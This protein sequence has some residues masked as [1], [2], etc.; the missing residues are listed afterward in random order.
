MFFLTLYNK[1]L[2]FL[3]MKHSPGLLLKHLLVGY[4]MLISRFTNALLKSKVISFNI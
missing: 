1:V 3:T 2:S 4:L